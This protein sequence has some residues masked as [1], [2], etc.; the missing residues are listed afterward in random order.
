MTFLQGRIR[1]DNVQ[2]RHA[3][4]LS[5]GRI[6]TTF[7]EHIWTNRYTRISMRTNGCMTSQRH[8]ALH[9]TAHSRESAKLQ[10]STSNLSRGRRLGSSESRSPSSQL[11]HK[12]ERGN[13]IDRFFEPRTR[14]V[15]H[16]CPFPIPMLASRILAKDAVP[17]QT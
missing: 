2:E 13:G 4:L 6:A 14:G 11:R 5:S 16:T 12:T 17:G 15:C 10:R 1:G 8:M 7:V 9:G 3:V